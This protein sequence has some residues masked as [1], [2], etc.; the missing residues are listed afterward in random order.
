MAE[1]LEKLITFSAS[2]ENG[3]MFEN[4][5]LNTA[6]LAAAA[7]YELYGDKGIIEKVEFS[8]LKDKSGENFDAALAFAASVSGMSVPTTKEQFAFCMDNA[9]FRS[10][11]NSIVARTLSTM[12]VKYRCPQLDAIVDR[13]RVGIGDSWTG[14]VVSKAL[15]VAQRGS[16][17]SNNSSVFQEAK[18]GVTITPKP[19]VIGKSLDYIRLFA[20]KYDWAFHIAKVYAGLM[21]AKYQLA[22]NAYY[23]NVAI[24]STPFYQ[25]NFTAAAY[26][27]LAS[28]IKMFAGEDDL[29]AYG[30]LVAWNAVSALAS[31]GGF[32]TK[33]DYIRNAFLQKI[34]GIDSMILAQFT[35]AAAPFT[36]GNASTLRTIPDNKIL[37]VVGGADKPVKIVE[38]DYIR[39]KEVDA[40]DNNLNRME[41]VFT[42]SFDAGVVSANPFGLI[43]TTAGA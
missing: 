3:K 8:G 37:L 30:T 6:E 24:Q 31:Q 17:G 7:T 20:G 12:M 43:G 41:Y 19:M 9:T 13:I 27:Q 25:A 18:T 34:Y 23:N 35:N 29:T 2:E 21:F 4:I 38:E 1:K 28:D 33:D 36:S 5:V 11:M 26:T 15:P 22:V 39:V 16:Y 14:E 32:T 40:N 10:V 42:Q